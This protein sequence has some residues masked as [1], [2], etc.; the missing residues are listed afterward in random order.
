ML[1]ARYGED[2][3]NKLGD[4]LEVKTVAETQKKDKTQRRKGGD[5]KDRPQ[6]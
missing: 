1:R 3:V 4:R 2:F 6:R 5:R